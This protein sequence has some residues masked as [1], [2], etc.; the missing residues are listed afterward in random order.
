[1]AKALDAFQNGN[2][3]LALVLFEKEIRENSEDP[4]LYYHFAL[5]CFYTNNFKK[6]IVV[7]RE[8]IERFPRFIEIDRAYKILI[9]SLIQSK[10]YSVA[11]EE[12]Q[13]RLHISPN[14]EILL[15]FE[16]AIYEK[17]KQ[18][19]EAIGSHR[20][21]LRSNPEY[22]NSLNSLGYLLLTQRK[23]LSPDDLQEAIQCL[24]KAMSLAPTNPAYL[25]SFGTLLEKIGKKEQAIQ[26]LEKAVALSP[27]QSELWEHLSQLKKLG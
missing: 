5:S 12:V 3:A 16:A 21:I 11:K 2:Y 9:L 8:I 10:D 18:W 13:N 20:K 15:S 1:L 27:E 6:T 4:L 14:D 7:V 24:K 25:D 17:G 19:E 26:A 23:T 22:K